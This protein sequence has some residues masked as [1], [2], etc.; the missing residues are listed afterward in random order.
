MKK[1]ILT[2]FALVLGVSLALAQNK[3]SENTF[4]SNNNTSVSQTATN[5][6]GNTSSIN[7][8]DAG[9]AGN[10]FNTISVTQEG[11]NTSDVLI[12]DPATAGPA[13]ASFNSVT[14]EQ[15]GGE[16]SANA[17]SV[18]IEGGD[19]TTFQDQDGFGNNAEIGISRTY[20]TQ[21]NDTGNDHTQIQ[22]G[23]NNQ[24]RARAFNGP[25]D[26]LQEQIGNANTSDL[27][28]TQGGDNTATLR[29]LGNNNDVDVEQFKDDNEAQVTQNGDANITSVTQL[30]GD[31]RF[32]QRGFGDGNIISST[33][34]VGTGNNA[35][36]EMGGD[37]NVV[38]VN[39]A[40]SDNQLFF[41]FQGT[42]SN[43]VSSN[44]VGLDQVGDN[45]TISGDFASGST[46]NT[47]SV[48]QQGNDNDVTSGSMFAQDGVFINGN[49]NTM[50][51]DQLGNGNSSINSMVGNDNVGDI[52]Q[53]GT[54]NESILGQMGDMNNASVT[55]GSMDNISNIMQTGNTNNATVNQQ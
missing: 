42:N 30:V 17:A 25:N 41:D 13:T 52:N 15:N 45:N 44:V 35:V 40:G 48:M 19:N 37:A 21:G 14:V 47:V 33:Q 27:L 1:V 50:T 31:Q 23:D 2:A 54:G 5:A 36:L 51:I 24:A 20:G 4:G 38:T 7:L 49:T 28:Q 53:N 34:G 43:R 8:G 55:Q 29:Q 9:N 6:V 39:Q 18:K 10:D 46:S 22:T 11:E 16:G 26:G 12:N 3:S 32:V